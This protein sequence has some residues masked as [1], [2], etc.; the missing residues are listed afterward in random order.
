MA[1]RRYANQRLL[2]SYPANGMPRQRGSRLASWPNHPENVPSLTEREMDVSG[3]K[4][5]AELKSVDVS[6]G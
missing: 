3:I 4:T 5:Y 2:P 6:L 1:E